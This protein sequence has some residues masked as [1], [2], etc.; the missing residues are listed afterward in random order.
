MTYL[1]AAINIARQAPIVTPFGPNVTKVFT[2]TPAPPIPSTKAAI[3]I[4]GVNVPYP[5]TPLTK[6]VAP[7]KPILVMKPTTV[8]TPKPPAPSAPVTVNVTSS[9]GGSGGAPLPP[10]IA[11]ETSDMTGGAM[12]FGSSPLPLILIG[13]A[14]LFLMNRKKGRR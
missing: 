5:S 11:D 7:V 4:P 3:P 8:A 13:L 9:G 1:G 12:S 2:P 6:P 14:A 10:L